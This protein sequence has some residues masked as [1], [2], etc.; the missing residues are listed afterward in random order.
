MVITDEQL[1]FHLVS[2][3]GYLGA[4][5]GA[6]LANR[7][8]HYHKHWS[9][10]HEPGYLGYDPDRLEALLEAAEAHRVVV[11]RGTPWKPARPWAPRPKPPPRVAAMRRWRWIFIALVLVPLVGG[12]TGIVMHG[13][14]FFV[15][16]QAGVGQTSGDGLTENQGPGQP[17]APAPGHPAIPDGG[18]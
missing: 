8:A 4:L 13:L 16:R 7:E 2:E 5:S 6:P 1:A 12:I 9:C 18:S 10:S 17:G 11:A 3:H 15:F 14:P